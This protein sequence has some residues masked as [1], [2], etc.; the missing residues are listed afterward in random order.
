MGKW[1]L[2]LALAFPVWAESYHDAAAR[3]ATQGA[4]LTLPDSWGGRM[5]S[6]DLKLLLGTLEIVANWGPD[7]QLERP[8]LQDLISNM[9]R[10]RERLRVGLAVLPQPGPVNAW[11]E[12]VSVLEKGLERAERSFGG[13]NLPS[14]GEIAVSDLK[15]DWDPP[16]CEDPKEL[17]LQA[18]S[19]RIDVQQISNPYIVPGN[20]FGLFGLGYGGGWS[21]DFQ[22][23][24]TAAF[25]YESACNSRYQDVRQTTRAYQKVHDAFERVFP[26]LRANAHS[27]RNVERAIRRLDAFYAAL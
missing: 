7:S 4:S 11:L 25:N 26:Q 2:L 5:S 18:R 1:I 17:L 20:G 13:Y 6:E 24:Q 23:L 8:A 15:R 19:L 16:G 21:G 3:L 12:E 10:F 27:F 22:Q 14:A 9:R